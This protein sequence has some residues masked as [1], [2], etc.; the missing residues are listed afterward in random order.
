M[1]SP[2]TAARMDASP[3]TRL[4][5]EHAEAPDLVDRLVPLVYDELREAAHRQLRRS[6]PATIHTTELV[7]EAY[8]KLASSARAPASSRAH[9]FGAAARAM[10]Q[11]L[12]DRARARTASKR[13]QHRVTVDFDRADLGDGAADEILAVHEALERLAAFDERAA[14]VVE[15]RF[16][17][18]L[19]EPE[20][21]EALGVGERTVS[22]DWAL[23]RAWLHTAL[24]EA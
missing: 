8:A 9:F 3:V 7:H 11:V 16:F 24:S 6:G 23:A 18:G 19:T 2:P 21:A 4:L 22:R 15:C 14:R 5:E 12:V 1:L 13:P 20:T 10:R 17:G